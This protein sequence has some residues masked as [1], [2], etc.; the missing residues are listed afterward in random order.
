MLGE[1]T[2]RMTKF[3]RTGLQLVM[4]GSACVAVP[5]LAEEDNNTIIVNGQRQAY[6]GDFTLKET[7]QAITQIDAEIIDQNAILRLADVLDLSASVARQNNFGGLWDAYAV[8]GFAGDENL[9]SGYLVNGFNGGRGFGGTRDASGIERVEVLKGP[10][11][12]LFGRGEPG[13]TVNIVTKVADFDTRGRITA[14]AG[15]FDRRRADGDVNIA[16]GDVAA[17]RLIGYYE[18]AGSFRDTVRSERLGFLPSVLFR[19]GE[20]TTLTYD[21]ELSRQEADFDRGVPAIRGALGLV[22]RSRFLGEPGDGPTAA[23]ATG[24]QVQ[25]RHEFSDDWS[26]MLG[27]Q[28][29]ET[30]LEGF[31]SDAELVASRQRL[32]RDGRSL[33]RQRRSRLYEG[34]HFVLR[35]EV[36]GKF[37]T[38]SLS[39]RVLI[40]VDYDEFDNSQLF[41][42]FRPPVIGAATSPQAANDIDIFNPV[43]GRFPL[44]TPAPL[45]N[46]LDQQRAV[47]AYVQD[48]ITLSDSLQLRIG[49]RFDDITVETLNR[50]NN[51][52]ASR[53][54]KRFSPQAGIVFTASDAVSLYAAYGEGF[55][56]N[57][58]AT[59]AGTLF[60]PE[61]S[62]S[63][64][65]GA[66]F[67]LLDGA[68]EGTVSL[69]TLSK[70]NVLAADPANPGF[71]LPIGK[72]RSRGLE[73]DIA[74]K[75]PGDVD[76][77]LSYAY[78]D[79]EARANVTDLNFG[80]AIRSGDRLINI[81]RHSAN[82]QLSRG[83]D[84]GTT[85]L[86]VGG[87]VQYVGKRLGET[88]TTFELP[89][90]VLTRVF[91][92][93]KL[94]EHLEVIA[95]VTN[96]FNTTYYTNSFAQLWVQ[97]GSPRAASVAV[98]VSF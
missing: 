73:V 33:S 97:P 94:Q 98:R 75:L 2:L 22:P 79:A 27:G 8:R 81:P 40:G 56:A 63:A 93:W 24:H 45:T 39:H 13:G 67:G 88:A 7:P 29:R 44:P 48:Q 31:S 72:A 77:W 19:L 25:L 38:G 34:E 9:P 50:A 89:D 84:I 49:G 61:T 46:R 65:V 91:A 52:A 30:R 11:A 86:N 17:I 95:N 54:Y 47:G 28:Y 4:A 18:D 21:L 62:K 74:G 5:A 43:Y 15:S 26:V 57:L 14:L 92:S 35:G 71:S 3:I 58:G 60:D 42:R 90:Y 32:F 68:L 36:A 12:A 70:S 1:D 51:V 82:I 55:R 96:L 76:L 37:D 16:I 20:R 80:L 87:G 85:R 78:V 41:L 23:D 59:A 53:S 66:K 83:F 69:F 6:R 10:N 64:E